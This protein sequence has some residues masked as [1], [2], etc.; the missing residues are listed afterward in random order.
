MIPAV[1]PQK[2][3]HIRHFVKMAVCL[4]GDTLVKDDFDFF[5]NDKLIAR[6]KKTSRSG[7]PLNSFQWSRGLVPEGMF[8]AGSTHPDAF[9]SR[10]FGLVAIVD[11][12]PLELIK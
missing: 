10:Y 8:F 1:G 9:D 12:V 3:E 4:P 6:A 2:S 11:A 7:Q 5:C